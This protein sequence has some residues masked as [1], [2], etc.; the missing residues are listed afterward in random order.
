MKRAAGKR[1]AVRG[2]LTLAVV[3]PLC[4]GCSSAA[5]TASRPDARPSTSQRAEITLAEIRAMGERPTTANDIVKML[6]PRMLLGRTQTG[7]ERPPA[8][9][10]NEIAGL[11]VHVDDTRIGDVDFLATIPAKAVASIR[12]LSPSEASTQYGNGH[13]AGVIAVTTLVGHW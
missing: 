7:I 13:T 12:W 9:H 4:F 6:R 5:S 11:H 1:R 10:P 3:A 2:G 8:M